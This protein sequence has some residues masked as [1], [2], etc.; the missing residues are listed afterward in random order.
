MV[1]PVCRGVMTLPYCP[2]VAP[3]CTLLVPVNGCAES[4]VA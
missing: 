1:N 2:A 3:L 4:T